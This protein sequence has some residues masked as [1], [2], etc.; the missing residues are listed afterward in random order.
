M[1]GRGLV[2]VLGGL[3]QQVGLSLW[4]GGILIV[5]AAVAPAAFRTLPTRS[6]AGEVVG[7]CLR[8]FNTVTLV[9][10]ALLLLGLAV[11]WLNRRRTTWERTLELVRFLCTA[12]ALGI[13]LFL[14]T[15]L[16]PRM[17]ALRQ[18]SAMG[19]QFDAMHHTYTT[20]TYLQLALLL[21]VATLSA[22]LS[23]PKAIPASTAVGSGPPLRA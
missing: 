8:G 17:D 19:P 20:F 10:A 16:M 18:A 1:K 4:L 15:S 21:A 6:M 12:I 2:L 11:D 9:A 3:A 23:L 13:T 7:A 5:G 14:M 22:Q